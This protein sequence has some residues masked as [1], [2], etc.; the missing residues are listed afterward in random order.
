MSDFF[1]GL[2]EKLLV[3]AI[4][5]AAMAVVVTAVALVLSTTGHDCMRPASIRWWRPWSPW[6]STSSG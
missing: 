6:A 5:V 1:D 2:R 3:P 4:G